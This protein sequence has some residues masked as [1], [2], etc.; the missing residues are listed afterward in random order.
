MKDV[1]DHV[2]IA[3]STLSNGLNTENPA[4]KHL[5]RIAELVAVDVRWLRTGEQQYA[6]SWHGEA[7][8]QA[9]QRG[10][11]QQGRTTTDINWDRRQQKIRR[12]KDA[13]VE[14]ESDDGIA[15]S[16]QSADDLSGEPP[17]EHNP[18]YRERFERIGDIA[19]DL[20]EVLEDAP[21]EKLAKKLLTR[22][23]KLTGRLKP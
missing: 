7:G 15:L 13:G 23:L 14:Y 19:E 11:A 12:V 21:I 3:S 1:S 16:P 5:P 17:E 9:T 8:T 2:G 22:L 10:V 20:A 18:Y 4:Y 6:P